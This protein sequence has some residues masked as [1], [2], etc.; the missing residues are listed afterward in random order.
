MSA[1][2]RIA[3]G[4]V[5][6]QLAFDGARTGAGDHLAGGE[7]LH[8][9]LARELV[10]RRAEGLRGHLHVE[11]L[12]HGLAGSLC[13]NHGGPDGENGTERR[14]KRGIQQML[15]RQGTHKKATPVF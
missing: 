1:V 13:R 8:A 3:K 5:D 10:E 2:R 15:T 12:R 7:H 9:G 11:H 14:G 6:R 4:L